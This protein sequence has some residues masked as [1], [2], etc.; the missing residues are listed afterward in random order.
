[1]EISVLLTRLV[2][3]VGAPQVPGASFPFTGPVLEV[4]VEARAPV[5]LEFADGA[6][7]RVRVEDRTR[8]A[9]AAY[10]L[11]DATLTLAHRSPARG[12]YRVEAPPGTR[13]VLR[14]N[15]V[16]VAALAPGRRR[17]LVWYSELEPAPAETAEATPPPTPREFRIE[18]FRGPLV[19]DSMDVAYP[20]RARV[21]RIRLGRRD[22]RIV[23]DRS[24]RFSFHGPSRWGV[25]T[26][27]DT[28]ARVDLE[29][30][31]GTERFT[32]RVRGRAI[33]V[34]DPSGARALCGPASRVARPDGG[35]DW[36]FHL[37][38]GLSCPEERDRAPPAAAL[39]YAAAPAR[40]ARGRARRCRGRAFRSATQKPRAARGDPRGVT[41][42][43]RHGAHGSGRQ[44][45]HASNAGCRVRFAGVPP[46]AGT[47]KISALPPRWLEYAIHW[48]SGDHAAAPSG[49]ASNV[50]RRR[51]DPSASIT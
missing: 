9:A 28:A 29:L 51:F 26:V 50:S 14:V 22:F 12:D 17:H 38:A 1:V 19:V 2:V 24:V 21:F 32:V 3:A 15:H 43:P 4:E 16:E 47:R 23:G 31:A 25:M 48:P 5:R 39:L 6:A 13:V 46:S 34:L 35:E 45:G 7:D 44:S 49:Y 20:E 8:P 42:N 33:W 41:P 37:E 18:P 30:P 36:T 40:T 27:G 10:A 11:T